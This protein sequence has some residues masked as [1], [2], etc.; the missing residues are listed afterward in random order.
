MPDAIELATALSSAVLAP[1]PRLMFATAGRIAL[2]VT[3]SMPC[4]MSVVVPLP[5]QPSTRT[6]LICAPLATPN[7]EPAAVPATCVP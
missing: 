5:V 3:Q 7:V 1:P 6:P 2:L 4:T